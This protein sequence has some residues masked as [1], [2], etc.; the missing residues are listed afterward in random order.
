MDSEIS[1]ISTQD[2]APKIPQRTLEDVRR[3]EKEK[4]AIIK[5][6][7]GYENLPEED[8][9][10][11]VNEKYEQL[12]SLDVQDPV[13]NLKRYNASLENSGN[14]N[15]S[16]A[17][18]INLGGEIEIPPEVEIKQTPVPENNNDFD[19]V[20]YAQNEMA[21]QKSQ[22]E[23]APPTPVPE[24]QPQTEA[25]SIVPEPAPIASESQTVQPEISQGQQEV[26]DIFKKLDE[27][28]KKKA[29]ESAAN[30]QPE[31]VPVTPV[32]A[33]ETT[34]QKLTEQDEKNLED[35]EQR[36]KSG[37]AINVVDKRDFNSSESVPAAQ[38]GASGEVKPE[39][40]PGQKE[41]QD[42]FKKLDEADKLKEPQPEPV[43]TTQEPKVENA[44]GEQIQ[45][46]EKTVDE[47]EE[48]KQIRN[49]LAKAEAKRN[50]KNP[51]LAYELNLS[52]LRMK[53]A[54][55]KEKIAAAV[56][57][58]AYQRIGIGEGQTPTEE[59][60]KKINDLIFEELVVNENKNY[61]DAL[62]ANREETW[63]DKTKIEMAKILGSKAMQGY[64]KLPRWKRIAI[65]TAIGTGVGIAAGAAGALGVAG[66]TAFRVARAAASFGGSTLGTI[67]GEKKKSWSIETLNQNENGEI[68]ELKESTKSLEEKA[69]GYAKIK[70]KYEKER[71]K[72]QIKKAALTIGMGVG[73]GLLSG[74]SGHVFVGVG[75]SADALHASGPKADTVGHLQNAKPN[76][77]EQT[78]TVE[79]NIEAEKIFSDPSMLHHSVKSGD[80]LWKI[81]NKTFEHNDKF[82]GLTEAQKQNVV[83]FFTNKAINNPGKYGFTSDPDFGIR[84]EVGKE[85]DLNKLIGNPEEYSKVVG[86][87]LKKTLAEQQ[88]ILGRS[89]KLNAFVKEYPNTKLTNSKIAEILGEKPKVAIPQE[90]G[91]K[92]PN[93][94]EKE[95]YKNAMEPHPLTSP[96]T[97][98][99]GL[100]H[101]A[102]GVHQIHNEIADAKQRLA[103]LEG[104]VKNPNLERSL[105]ADSKAYMS[106]V[107]FNKSIEGAFKSGIDSIYGSKGVMG[108]GR[109]VGVNSKEWGEMARLPAN[110]VVEY[111]TGDSTKS[112]LSAAIVDKLAKS[113]NHNTLMRQAIGLM[114]QTGGTV[115]PFENENM[116]QFIKRLGGYIMTHTP[117]M[118]NT[119]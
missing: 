51:N 48:F 34:S 108:F 62:K 99:P 87:A 98:P 92:T 97:Q 24:L 32:S 79:P 37:E 83:S 104:K 20:K 56:K 73:A 115:K 65:T 26:Q 9:Q 13:E 102:S 70:E 2:G 14:G 110:K 106:D 15:E 27:A 57:K 113:K 39:L 117:S 10:N 49:E 47:L 55:S 64:L 30:K 95:I 61:T 53:Y 21:R 59:Q 40:S 77:S 111:Y 105:A 42:I 1:N 8:L 3:L 109:T 16:G 29:E 75:K 44:T 88:E 89:A 22:T 66:Y 12:S 76:L 118:K 78:H 81:L 17:E 63:K 45:I 36:K 54:E 71:K 4:N 33:P 93:Q 100:H 85:I 5:M 35:F 96:M 7:D 60:Q 31:P 18:E 41:V 119:A 19:Y 107:E 28:D 43:S 38:E 50:S 23:G 84:V 94:L 114:G 58:D 82:K 90:T 69:K 68:R 46:T 74:L 116:E 6:P 86:G 72:A 101:D 112:G 25:A 91:I 11:L 80:S 52:K 67:I 103:E